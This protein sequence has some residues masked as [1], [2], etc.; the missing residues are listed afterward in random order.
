MKVRTLLFASV[1]LKYLLPHDDEAL[2]P[3]TYNVSNSSEK[4]LLTAR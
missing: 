1:Q 3:R 4:T 2:V